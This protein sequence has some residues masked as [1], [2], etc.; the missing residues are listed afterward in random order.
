M[1]NQNT[2]YYT[3]LSVLFV[4]VLLMANIIGEKPLLFG[5]FIIPAGLLLFPIS[6]VL[7]DILTEIYGFTKA[8][9]VIWMGL[10]MNILLA[11]ICQ[12]VIRLPT[13]D[14]WQQSEAYAEILGSS[15]RLMVISVMTYIISELS[16]AYLVAKFK[17][18]IPGYF[19]LRALCANWIGVAIET[20]L[21]VPLSFYGRIS[22]EALFNL[23]FFYYIF[24]VLYALCA[25]PFASKLVSILKKKE[26]SP[27][28]I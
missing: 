11:V 13:V 6:Y 17:E 5:S 19:W 24:K 12:L 25:I 8:R 21:F 15:S 23:F 14:T 4:S 16:N 26:M 10:W 3:F 22:N 27:I 18:K 1:Q 9:Q 2:Q 20:A 7:G 28:V